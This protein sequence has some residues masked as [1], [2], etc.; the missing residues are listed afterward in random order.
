MTSKKKNTKK[1]EESSFQPTSLPV[2]FH[3]AVRNCDTIR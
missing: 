2:R 3:G 1:N